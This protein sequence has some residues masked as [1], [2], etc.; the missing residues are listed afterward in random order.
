MTAF[1]L[2]EPGRG[3][4]LRA[5]VLRK[6]LE[7]EIK[8]GELKHH[9]CS[10]CGKLVPTKKIIPYDDRLL[11]EKCYKELTEYPVTRQKNACS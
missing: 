3:E 9:A 11:C 10:N 5:E 8:K 6:I 4:V 7:K 2:Y 1:R